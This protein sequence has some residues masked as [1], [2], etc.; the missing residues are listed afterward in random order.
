[1][2][3]TLRSRMLSAPV[4]GICIALV[5]AG[6]AYATWPGPLPRGAAT[7]TVCGWSGGGVV[8]T[9]AV[10]NLGSSTA[11]FEVRPRFWLRGL[12]LRRGEPQFVR[13]PAGAERRWSSVQRLMAPRHIG[14]GIRRCAAVV[15]TVPP[16]SGDD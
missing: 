5:I 7:A 9:G 14:V 10:R 13:V 6:A 3:Q 8:F 15:S 1:M 4:V 16:P 2:W 11:Q 12:G